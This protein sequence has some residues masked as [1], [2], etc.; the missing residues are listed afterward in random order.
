[1][2]SAQDIREFNGYLRQCT[3]RQLAGVLE[4][5]IAANREEYTE[6]TKAEACRRGFAY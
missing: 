6:L 3:D 1:M 4:K 2:I 5:E